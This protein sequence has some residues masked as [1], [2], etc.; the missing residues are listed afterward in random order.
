MYVTISRGYFGAH[1]KASTSIHDA[2]NKWLGHMGIQCDCDCVHITVSL[3]CCRKFKVHAVNAYTHCM[4]IWLK[5]SLWPCCWTTG[6]SATSHYRTSSRLSFYLFNLRG[7]MAEVN[8]YILLRRYTQGPHGC[9]IKA[10][11]AL[12]ED[13]KIPLLLSQMRGD[14]YIY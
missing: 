6:S 3:K 12:D 7:S 2:C 10:C 13:M 4:S 14:I 5:I 8:T 11:P 1:C 9:V